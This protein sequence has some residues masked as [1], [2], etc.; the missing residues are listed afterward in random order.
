MNQQHHTRPG[1][2]SEK[3]VAVQLTSDTEVFMLI[4]EI[5]TEITKTAF[6][7][8]HDQTALS[9]IGIGSSHLLMCISLSL[10]AH[11]CISALMYPGPPVCLFALSNLSV[12]INSQ[13]RNKMPVHSF[14]IRFDVEDMENL[15]CQTDS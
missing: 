7:Q 14:H 4:L 5:K 10:H 6:S 3:T 8:S 13:P 9:G 2:C 12:S 15:K 1:Q 11:A